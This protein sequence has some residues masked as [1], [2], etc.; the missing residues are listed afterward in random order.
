MAGEHHFEGVDYPTREARNVGIVK[1]WIEGAPPDPPAP[2]GTYALAMHAG[3]AHD[4]IW[5]D[6]QECWPDCRMTF[7]EYRAAVDEIARDG[8]LDRWTAS[9]GT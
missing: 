9:P 7:I 2:F 8:T 3:T 6:I 1:A 4:I 5:E